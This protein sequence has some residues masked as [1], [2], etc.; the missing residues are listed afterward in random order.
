M[1]PVN[2]NN[3]LYRY[4]SDSS[5]LLLHEAG[6]ALLEHNKH[7]RDIGLVAMERDAWQ[8]AKVELAEL[9]LTIPAKIV[10]DNLDTYHD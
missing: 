5:Y 8:Y 7:S 4:N 2:K 9:S 10:E 6:H 3:T 1:G